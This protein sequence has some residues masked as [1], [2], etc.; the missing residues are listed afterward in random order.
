MAK[1]DNFDEL[2]EKIIF[3]YRHDEDRKPIFIEKNEFIKMYPDTYEYLLTQ[4]ELLSTRDKGNGKYSDWYAFGRSQ[5]LE[6]R[7]EKLFFPQLVKKGFETFYSE[8]KNLY[9]YNGMCAYASKRELKKLQKIMKSDEFWKYIENRA[10]HYA[11][12]YYGLG[13][14]YLK[15][16]GII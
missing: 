1:Y 10:K 7:K 14:N 12:S 9:F 15:D 8:D 6:L 11:S 3:P 2:V 5:S 4:K 16:F 13:R